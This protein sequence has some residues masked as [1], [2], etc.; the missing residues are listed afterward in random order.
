MDS[1]YLDHHHTKD[2]SFNSARNFNL[3]Q[4]VGSALMDQLDAVMDA[5]S[6]GVKEQDFEKALELQRKAQ[7]Y[8]DFIAAENSMDFH[9]PQEAA[10]IWG[11]AADNARQGQIE[12]IRSTSKVQD[13]Y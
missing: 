10:R 9:A 3:L 1:T 2:R 12:A 7:W 8:L 5:K 6:V 11:E 4:K 13:H